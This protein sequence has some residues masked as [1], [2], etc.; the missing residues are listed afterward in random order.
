MTPHFQVW[1]WLPA[2]QR[3]PQ[4]QGRCQ[5][6]GPGSEGEGTGYVHHRGRQAGQG[7]SQDRAGHCGQFPGMRRAGDWTALPL[8]H[9][10][11]VYA[12]LHQE[13]GDDKEGG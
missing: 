1:E 8:W 12:L 4:D 9:L 3:P 2:G 11:I 5:L 6:T 7:Q 13:P 10:Q